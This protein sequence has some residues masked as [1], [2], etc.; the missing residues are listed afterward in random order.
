MR[1]NQVSW[2]NFMSYGNKWQQIEFIEDN[3]LFLL[4]G[5]NGAGKSAIKGVIEFALYGK[6]VG[7]TLKDIPN[8]LNSELEVKIWLEASGHKIFIH[9]GLE[10]AIFKVQVSDI[11]NFG[12]MVNKTVVQEEL[13]KLF[14]I[15]NHIFNNTVM[16]S[17]N[18]FKSFIKMKVEDKRKIIDKVFGL[19]IINKMRELLKVD[20]KEIKTK[21]TTLNIQINS[22]TNELSRITEKLKSVEKEIKEVNYQKKGELEQAIAKYKNLL[23]KLDPKEVSVKQLLSE[24]QL[25]IDTLSKKIN[26]VY[27]VIESYKEKLELFN[28]DKCPTCGTDLSSEFFINLKDDYIKE[29]EL[30]KNLYKELKEEKVTWN[31]ELQTINETISLIKDKKNKYKIGRAHV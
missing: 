28:N 27:R 15:P 29:L 14:G 8:R 11:P 16:L 18:D 4:H 5:K 10:P 26:K 21:N 6:I 1:I 20:L 19:T 2:K 30:N 22:L 23:K 17:I 12:E 7:K 13:E 9:R 25:G 31:E 3:N 24:K